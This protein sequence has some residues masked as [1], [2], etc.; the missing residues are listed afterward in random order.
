MYVSGFGTLC[1][2]FFSTEVVET[3]LHSF[4]DQLL[5]LFQAGGATADLDCLTGCLLLG[6][7]DL[8]ASLLADCVDLAAT[9]ANNE[10]VG[11]GVGQDEIAGGRLLRRGG[12]G[13]LNSGA[14]LGDVLGGSGQ[15]PGVGSGGGRGHGVVDNGPGVGIGGSI[16]VVGDQGHG[17]AVG[18]GFLSGIDGGD[19]LTGVVDGD[20]VVVAQAAEDGAIVSHGVVQVAGDFNGLGVLLLQHRLD[21]LLGAFHGGAGTLQLDVRTARAKLGDVEGHVELGLDA[22]TGVTSA[23]DEQTVLGSGDVENLGDLILAFLYKLLDSGD[24]AVDNLAV[25]FETN[26]RLGAVGLGEADH[27]GG[28]AVT[29]TPS[30]SHNLADVGTCNRLV[31]AIEWRFLQ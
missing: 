21:V 10:A 19:R 18:T 24:D 14:S 2:I 16:G 15:D 22:A 25:T 12:D 13:L 3:I 20:L 23:A 5:R 26:G 11:L 6:H 8:A 9:L 1:L 31:N 7:V 17:R 29:G 30:L 28:T 27:S 4:K